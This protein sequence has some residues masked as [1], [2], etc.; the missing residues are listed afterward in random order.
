VTTID[1]NAPNIVDTVSS[2]APTTQPGPERST[3]SDCDKDPIN[4]T[5][6][7]LLLKERR[8]T[9]ETTL[10][11][12][13]KARRSVSG[14]RSNEWRLKKE[15][16]QAM[17]VRR[18]HS[19]TTVASPYLN[20][21]F[22]FEGE[23]QHRTN[24]SSWA[25]GSDCLGSFPSIEWCDEL[26][27]GPSDICRDVDSFSLSDEFRFSDDTKLHFA[28]QNSW[29]NETLHRMKAASLESGRMHRSMAFLSDLNVLSQ[30]IER[31][32]QILNQRRVD[33]HYR[34]K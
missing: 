32:P 2:Y 8:P 31:H 7:G 24:S 14:K 27:D 16:R 12:T 15:F 20:I 6:I 22:S 11:V 9:M 18:T 1:S 13:S 21:P 33:E 10:K 17:M 19:K 34:R 4:M 25:G 23:V 30:Q 26:D 29:L 28:D 3:Q 5:K